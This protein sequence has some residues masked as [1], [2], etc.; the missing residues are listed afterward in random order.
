MSAGTTLAAVKPKPSLR[1]RLLWQLLPAL[2]LSWVVGSMISIYT[3]SYF[4]QQAY[5]RSILDDAQLLAA[6]TKLLN[7]KLVLDAREEDLQSILFDPSETIYYAIESRDGRVIAGTPGLLTRSLSGV[8][9]MGRKSELPDTIYTDLHWAQKK[10]KAVVLTRK[11]PEPY[12]VVVAVTT[13]ARDALL[14]QLTVASLAPRT[15]LMLA[16]LL[17]FRWVIRRELRPLTH[18]EESVEERDSADLSPLP[19][20]LTTQAATRDVHSLS[21]SIDGLLKRVAQSLSQQREFAGNVAHELRTPLAG[22]RAAAEFG[23]AQSDPEQWRKQL[24][25]VLRSEQRASHMVEQLL[26]LALASESSHGVQ[27]EQ[28]RLN[29]IV[30]EQV[31]AV[32]PKADQL[33][34][35][36]VASGLDEELLIRADRALVE[37]LLSNLIDNAFRYGRRAGGGDVIS[38]V[39]SRVAGEAWLSVIDQGPGIPAEQREQLLQRWTQGEDGARIG[40]GAGLGLSICQRFAKLMHAQL[41]LDSGFGG[42]GLRASVVFSGSSNGKAAVA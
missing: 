7:G 36:L 3:S 6:H 39:L 14:S 24:Q 8:G 38:V 42:H 26:M 16:L 4:M 37:G 2:L 35:E 41:V 22:V 13:G 11:D 27:M 15:L 20:Q 32:L 30:R 9:S 34:I 33:G 12:Q 29:D 10:M 17:W 31:L 21:S 18:L 40:T 5:D 28:L 1:S 19:Q 23:L 25:E